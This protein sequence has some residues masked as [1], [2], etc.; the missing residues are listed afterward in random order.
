MAGRHLL[1]AA[2]TAQGLAA[3]CARLLTE[4]DLRRRLVDAAHELHLH[5]FER[6][7]V[8]DRIAAG[9]TG[10]TRCGAVTGP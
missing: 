7:V 2:D 9:R 3:A 6:E 1:L 4:T 5:A 8:E 10:G